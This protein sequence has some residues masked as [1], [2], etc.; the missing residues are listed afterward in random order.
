MICLASRYAGFYKILFIV[1]NSTLAILDENVPLILL[2]IATDM[3]NSH[4]HR[5]TVIARKIYLP[6][7]AE[8]ATFTIV[9][10]EQTWHFRTARQKKYKFLSH[11]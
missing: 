3:S 9:R 1:R 11:V 2:Q 7:E 4:S 5:A 10:R 6:G 8:N